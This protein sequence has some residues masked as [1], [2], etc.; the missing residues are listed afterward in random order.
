MRWRLH[1]PLKRVKL[2]F[3]M[4]TAATARRRRPTSI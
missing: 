2:L 1:A 3:G 4:V